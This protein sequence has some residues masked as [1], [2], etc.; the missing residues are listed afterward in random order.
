[1]STLRR[2][3]FILWM[4]GITA[5]VGVIA[6]RD[7]PEAQGAPAPGAAAPPAR[8]LALDELDVRRI[9]VIEPDGKPRVIIASKGRMPGLIFEG[10][11]YPHPGRD[12]GGGLLF[13]NDE[14]TEAGGLTYRTARDGSTRDNGAALTIDQYDQNEQVALTYQRA[15]GYR[16]AG[17]SVYADLPEAS[18]LPVIQAYAQV[19]AAKTPSEKQQAQARLKELAKDG[20]GPVQVRV[21]VGKEN[22]AAKLVLGDKDGRPRLVLAV[23]GHGTPSI[24]LLDAGGKVVKR[25]AER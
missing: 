7:A 5:V 24:E 11:D 13:F 22:D 3:L 14:G 9:N 15:G 19:Q 16:N 6:I 10:K 2:T 18:L 25:I 20:V 17:L 12:V 8:R 1:M 23:D 21:F 4:A